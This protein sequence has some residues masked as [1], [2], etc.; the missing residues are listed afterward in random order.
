ML[1]P[2]LPAKTLE[3][4]LLLWFCRGAGWPA[5]NYFKRNKPKEH[6]PGGF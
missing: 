2:R 3:E 6:L 1:A 4:A 5:L